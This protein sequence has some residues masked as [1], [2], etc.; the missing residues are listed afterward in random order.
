MKPL[1]CI[2]ALLA[3]LLVAVPAQAQTLRQKIARDDVQMAQDTDP[4]MQ[5][6]IVLARQSLE[7]FLQTAKNPPK[8]SDGFAV[9][10]GVR[11]GDA[12]E[13]FWVIDFT[14]K[15]DLVT[16]TLANT[17]RIVRN[18]R[19]GQSYS[20]SKSDIVDWMYTDAKGR[21][22]GNL[23]MCALLIKEPAAE[24]TAIRKQYQITCPTLP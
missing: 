20:F 17:P 10:T 12:T 24:A 7:G 5:R 8:G 1:V 13:F 3:S 2:T 23:T 9:K 21:M 6:A 11:D 15:G 16:G 18:V 19:G 4:A 14:Q 22:Q